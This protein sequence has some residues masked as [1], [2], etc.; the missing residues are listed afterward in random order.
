MTMNE[1]RF[2]LSFSGMQV[3]D[4][5]GRLE[6]DSGSRRNRIEQRQTA[7]IKSDK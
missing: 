1:G 3:S 4:A 7:A 5:W 2:S 6:Y